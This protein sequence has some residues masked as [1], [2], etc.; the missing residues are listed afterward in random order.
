MNKLLLFISDYLRVF[1]MYA[2]N[3][4][5]VERYRI[6][7]AF[8]RT[9][10][11][12]RFMTSDPE[13]KL[14]DHPWTS[15]WCFV[16]CGYY[17]EERL[18]KLSPSVGIYTESARVNWFN[19]LGPITFHRIIFASENTWTLISTGPDEVLGNIIDFER[20]EKARKSWGFITSH[21][22]SPPG[23]APYAWRFD[24]WQPFGGERVED[25]PKG[26]PTGREY[27]KQLENLVDWKDIKNNFLTSADQV[28]KFG[29]ALMEILPDE[30]MI[31][32]N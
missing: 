30:G 28:R 13:D 27:R 3:R 1:V 26:A 7:K 19:Y 12:H 16:L 22:E 20:S 25:F 14:H 11:L 23:E 5:Y 15:A 31:H 21:R 24:Y 8:V 10:Y 6:G 9:W 18:K 2:K 17:I 29:D 32:D 4:P